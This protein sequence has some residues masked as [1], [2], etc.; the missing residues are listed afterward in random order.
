MI[1]AIYLLIGLAI[2]AKATSNAETMAS[3]RDLVTGGKAGAII[4]VVASLLLIV[5]WPTALV[6][7]FFQNSGE[8]E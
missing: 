2:Y 5:L 6:L 8:D 7:A 4:F 1:G 3:A